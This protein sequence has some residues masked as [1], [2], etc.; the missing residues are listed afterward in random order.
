M[1]LLFIFLVAQQLNMSSCFFCYFV[2]VCMSH[3]TY[4][5]GYMNL[6]HTRPIL[7]KCDHTKS[8]Q[9]NLNQTKLKQTKKDHT[10]VTKIQASPL[11]SVCPIL[12][13]YKLTFPNRTHKLDQTKITINGFCMA[14][15]AAQL[16]YG[17]V[18][19]CHTI[20]MV[21]NTKFRPS[22]RVVQCCGSVCWVVLWFW[23]AGRGGGLTITI[24]ITC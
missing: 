13:T 21:S 17:P 7:T 10:N 9:A 1:M 3:P 11:L 6:S 23:G 19:V 12:S 15:R 20:H 4:G 22:T 5:Y 14:K 16:L 2:C 8:I 24:S 18:L